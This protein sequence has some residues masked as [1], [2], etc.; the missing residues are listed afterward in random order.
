MRALDSPCWIRSLWRECVWHLLEK[1]FP[2]NHV[3]KVCI[4]PIGSRTHIP[5]TGCLLIAPFPPLHRGPGPFMHFRCVGGGPAVC[6]PKG[7]GGRIQVCRSIES[8]RY[9]LDQGYRHVQQ[10][11]NRHQWGVSRSMHIYIYIYVYVYTYTFSSFEPSQEGHLRIHA[12]E[13]CM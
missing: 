12:A 11:I 4:L 6:G 10:A 3:H 8:P 2:L 5:T 7:D 1:L 9:R 13:T